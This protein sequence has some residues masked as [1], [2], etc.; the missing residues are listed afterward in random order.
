MSMTKE[1]KRWKHGQAQY[2]LSTL[3]TT[4]VAFLFVSVTNDWDLLLTAISSHADCAAS[5]NRCKQ[6]ASFQTRQEI[7]RATAR[8]K[9]EIDVH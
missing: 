5:W 9:T 3:I 6:R 4:F 1:Q 7:R 2:G 8:R